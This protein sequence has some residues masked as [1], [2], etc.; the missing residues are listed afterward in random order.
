MSANCACHNHKESLVSLTFGFKSVDPLVQVFSSVCMP[1]PQG[2][3][4]LAPLPPV[5]LTLFCRIINWQ[6]LEVAKCEKVAGGNYSADQ[7]GLPR[8]EKE[9][10]E[11]GRKRFRLL[12]DNCRRFFTAHL[13]TQSK[14]D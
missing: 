10:E 4:L 5:L 8:R 2:V 13:S 12:P 7:Q 1:Q 6:K 3:W 14:Q 11:E 9:E